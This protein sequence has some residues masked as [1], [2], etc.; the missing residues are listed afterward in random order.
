MDPKINIREDDFSNPGQGFTQLSSIIQPMDSLNINLDNV[1]LGN[2][3]FTK[4]QKSE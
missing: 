1:S 3:D 4:Q 2:K